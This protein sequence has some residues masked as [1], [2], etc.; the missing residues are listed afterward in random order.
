MNV[1]KKIAALLKKDA[2]VAPEVAPS[3]EEECCEE[4]CQAASAIFKKICNDAGVGDKVLNSVSAI[5][6]FEAWYTGPCDMASI[7]GSIDAFRDE[8]PSVN[9]KLTGKL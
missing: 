8:Y 9:A 1:F 3:T 6:K 4:P 7:R 5:E 2:V